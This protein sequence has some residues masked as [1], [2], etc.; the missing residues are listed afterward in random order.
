MPPCA[1]GITRCLHALRKL[2]MSC[3][4][5]LDTVSVKDCLACTFLD[6]ALHVGL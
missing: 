3:E 1:N 4:C 5:F 6:W 2:H